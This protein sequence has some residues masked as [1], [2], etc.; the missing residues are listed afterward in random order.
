[1]GA[2]RKAIIWDL[3]GVIVDSLELRLAALRNAASGAGV[4]APDE[5]DLR[6]W[7][8][9]GPKFALRN[10]KGTNTSLRDFERFC[11]RVA[12]QYLTEF[13]GISQTLESLHQAGVRQGL[14]TSRTATDTERWLD[15]CHVPRLFQV[16]ITYSDGLRPKPDPA[17]LLVVAERLQVPVQESAYIGDTIDDGI[18]CER[19]GMPF[20]LAGWGTPDPDEVLATVS[21]D[22]V[23][24]SPPDVLSWV[25]GDN[26]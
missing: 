11:R 22:G 14:I 20:L 1:M 18:A 3:D 8:C 9:H 16:R 12:A 21:P 10:L 15:L 5:R 25:C 7:L 13:A 4:K 2:M 19:A 24:G 17:S 23:M 6:R 26:R